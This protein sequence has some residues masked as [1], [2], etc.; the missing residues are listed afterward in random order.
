PTNTFK[1]AITSLT[2]G[3]VA[4]NATNFSSTTSY[5]WLIASAS[6]GVTSFAANKFTLDDSA[7]TNSHNSA[8]FSIP[9]SANNVNPNSQGNTSVVTA[10]TP[11]KEVRVMQG[12]PSTTRPGVTA[13]SN[14]AGLDS[15]NFAVALGTGD[16]VSFSP[17]SGGPIAGGGSSNV[18]LGW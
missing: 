18:N 10:S 17:S 8:R 9:N 1:I 7:F 6:G 4:G 16:V 11:I 5:Q 12:Q 15:G 3:N 13:V 2:T 14:G